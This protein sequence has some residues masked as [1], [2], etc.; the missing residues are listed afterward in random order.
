MASTLEVENL[1]ALVA[2][3]RGGAGTSQQHE[4]N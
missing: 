2:V 1:R 3:V 4:T